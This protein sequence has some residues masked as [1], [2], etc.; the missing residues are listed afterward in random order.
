MYIVSIGGSMFYLPALPF[1]LM[2]TTIWQKEAGSVPIKPCPIVKI[3]CI[4]T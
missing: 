2:V 1:A 4:V 3:G